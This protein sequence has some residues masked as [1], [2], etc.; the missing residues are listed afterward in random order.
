MV[1]VPAFVWRGGRVRS[2]MTVGI[3]AGVPLAALAWLDSGM[4]LSA[5]LVLVIL[6]NLLRALDDL[7]DDQ[8]LARS[9]GVERTDRRGGDGGVGHRVRLG[10]QRSCVMHLPCAASSRT[11]L[12]AQA[13]AATIANAGRRRGH[14]PARSD[15]KPS[16]IV[17]VGGRAPADHRQS[18]S[19]VAVRVRA[20]GRCRDG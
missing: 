2:A 4:W 5:I 15:E 7:Q 18:A 16:L 3:G 1:T 9:P 14:R 19:V 6:V 17:R 20:A 10:P 13:A 11:V 8:V 12:V